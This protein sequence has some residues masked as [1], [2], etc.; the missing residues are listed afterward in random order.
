[1]TPKVVSFDLDGTLIEGPFTRALH[2]AA[3][4]IAGVDGEAAA[5][6]DLISK[7]ETLLQTDAAAAYDWETIVN[8]YAAEHGHGQVPTATVTER[9][10]AYAFAG[11]TELVHADTV[12]NLLRLRE[13]DWRLVIAT[14][15]WRRFQEPLIRGAGLAD[16]IDELIASDDVGVPKPA[17]AVFSRIRGSSD[18][19][20]HVG[21]RIDHDVVGA[22]RA[23]ATSVLLR[24]GLPLEGATDT[25][26]PEQTAD[27]NRYLDGV[28][29]SEFGA[30]RAP[31]NS[32]APEQ[33]P[34]LVASSLTSAV[35][36]ILAGH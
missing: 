36:L 8:G 1:M 28:I 18:R 10:N 27:L 9:I 29:E 5:F 30:A 20:I 7:H 31:G 13:A 34:D 6:A 15:G 19:H 26:T 2:D 25:L 33:V 32:L 3:R 4:D 12:E 14:N 23:Q 24:P 16:L 21:D 11:L 35:D 17:A 22:N